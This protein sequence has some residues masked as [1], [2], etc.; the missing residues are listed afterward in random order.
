[1]GAAPKLCVVEVPLIESCPEAAA[2]LADEVLAVACPVG[3]RRERAVAR[4]MAGE[5]F[6]ERDAR[7]ATD[8]ER[9]VLAHTVLANDG[10]ADAL[11][12]AVDAWWRRREEAGWPAR[13]RQAISHPPT[14]EGGAR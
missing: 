10:D 9:A 13:T 12:A 4:G 3:L 5:D 2:R 11:A 14:V 7:Q 1:M 6:D 8:E